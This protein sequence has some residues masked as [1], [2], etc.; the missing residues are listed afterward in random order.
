[1]LERPCWISNV[2][3]VRW[4]GLSGEQE[5][6]RQLSQGDLHGKGRRLEHDRQSS[7]LKLQS[8]R[9]ARR[10]RLSLPTGAWHDEAIQTAAGVARDGCG[11]AGVPVEDPEVIG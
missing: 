10:A 2:C 1:M 5:R 7:I 11:R 9:G 4:R 3:Q 6:R 8:K